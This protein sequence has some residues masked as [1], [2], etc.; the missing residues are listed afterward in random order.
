MNILTLIIIKIQET[1]KYG[2]DCARASPINQ[3]YI[4][5]IV[6]ANSFKTLSYHINNK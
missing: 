6:A 4:Y 1:R 3:I 2:I 5:Y